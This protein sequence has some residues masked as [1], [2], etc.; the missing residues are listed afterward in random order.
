MSQE[1]RIL[2]LNMVAGGKISA[3]QGAELLKAL[4]RSRVTDD[5]EV[6]Y[7]AEGIEAEGDGEK[8]DETGERSR[9]ARRP[10]R[11]RSLLEELL[12]GLTAGGLGFFGPNYHLEEELVGTFDASK[13]EIELA[14]CNGKI[15]VSAHDEPGYKVILR[16]SVRA[17]SEEEAQRRAAEMVEVITESDRLSI[18]TRSGWNNHGGVSV[19][20]RLPASLAYNFNIRSSN[21]RVEVIGLSG[22]KA[23][24]RTSN[25]SI[26]IG[27]GTFDLVNLKTSNG[28]I[29]SAC[30]ANSLKAHTS[31]G[32]VKALARGESDG[33]FDLYTSNGSI[34]FRT[35]NPSAGYRVRANTSLGR[36]RVELPDMDF[37]EMRKHRVEASSRNYEGK[38]PKIEVK[39]QTSNGSITIGEE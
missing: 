1:E 17:G 10:V 20:L 11:G 3:E 25:G 29:R 15:A 26:E 2:I 35:L 37:Q 7:E 4:E 28:S 14:T 31:N 9:E 30:A 21:G 23:V 19:E 32:S 6:E 39:A 5:Y 8:T 13:V 12:E 16:K 33:S 27:D 24:L 36:I 34:S 22:D 18:I 38:S